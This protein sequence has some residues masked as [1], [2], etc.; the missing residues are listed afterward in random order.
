MGHFSSWADARLVAPGVLL[1]TLYGL[2]TAGTLRQWRTEIAAAWAAHCRAYCID[3][4][5]TVLAATPAELAA[6][7][8]DAY[9]H[10]P[11]AVICAPAQWPTFVAASR[12]L[13][14]LGLVRMP[15]VDEASALRWARVQAS[16]PL[17]V[18]RP[19]RRRAPRAAR[20]AAQPPAHSHTGCAAA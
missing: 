13:A 12:R 14:K 9:G 5:R 2:H 16:E 11:A 15:F 20:R 4:S 17:A 10:M 19:S 8:R 3:Y 1:V 18:P 7:Q 6:M